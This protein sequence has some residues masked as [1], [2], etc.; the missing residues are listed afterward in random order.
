M[1]PEIARLFLAGTLARPPRRKRGWVAR[2]LK[3]FRR[4]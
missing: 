2:L 3:F 1:M 4:T